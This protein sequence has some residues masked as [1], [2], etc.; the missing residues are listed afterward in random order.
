[1]SPEQK[2]KLSAQMGFVKKYFLYLRSPRSE[3]QALLF[4]M[5]T[6]GDATNM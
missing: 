2:G 1:M 5:M 6:N 4:Q 3:G